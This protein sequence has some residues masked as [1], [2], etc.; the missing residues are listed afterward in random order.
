MTTHIEDIVPLLVAT[1]GVVVLVLRNPVE[2]GKRKL[3]SMSSIEAALHLTKL[4]V[5][6][7]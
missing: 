2:S 4:L 7:S 5:D 6:D 3:W 1:R